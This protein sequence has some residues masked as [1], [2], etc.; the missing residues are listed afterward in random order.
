MALKYIDTRKKTWKNRREWLIGFSALLIFLVSFF[1]P[2]KLFGDPFWLSF[3]LYASFPVAI[4][5]FVLKEPLQN[6]GFGA[7]KKFWGIALGIIFTIAFVAGHYFLVFHSPWAGQ[8]PVARVLVSGF[9]NFLLY[10]IFFSL[11]FQ[12]FSEVFFRGFLQLGLE[13]K[14]G[15]FSLLLAALLQ[16]VPYA[17]TNWAVLALVGC[18][19]LAAGIIVRQG[20]SIYYSAIAMWII[21]ASLDIMIIKVINQS[22]F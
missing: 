7:G 2:Q 21:S 11:P 14:L 8:I 4:M 17:R 6:F 5:I 22:R 15:I 16:T 9:L 12:F 3:F 20:R 13:K 19:S 10:E 1:F 18:S